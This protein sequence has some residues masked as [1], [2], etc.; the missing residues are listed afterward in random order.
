MMGLEFYTQIIYTQFAAGVTKTVLHGYSSIAGSDDSTYWPGHEG[1]WP[2]FSE[3]FGCRQ[4]AWQH[5]N[6]WTRMIA[7]YQM[8]LRKG[9]PRMDLGILRL[10]YNFNNLYFDG[11]NEKEL[12]ESK[13]MRG[14]AGVYWKDMKL[15]HAGFTWDYFAPQLV[16]EPFVNFENG[17]AYT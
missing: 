1:M 12:Y 10:N 14:D 13:L 17:Q 8:V 2:V 4:P 9:K 6:E 15:Q 3:R 7:R 5:Y 11:E 16:E